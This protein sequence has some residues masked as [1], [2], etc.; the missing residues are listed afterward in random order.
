MVDFALKKGLMLFFGM[1]RGLMLKA[2]GTSFRIIIMK[3]A[4][5][6]FFLFMYVSDGLPKASSHRDI[7]TQINFLSTY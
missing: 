7:L 1:K 4:D 3:M 2:T 6:P 5:Y